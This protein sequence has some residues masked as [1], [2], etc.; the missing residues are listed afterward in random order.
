MKFIYYFL[1]TAVVGLSAFTTGYGQESGGNIFLD[2][3]SAVVTYPAVEWIKGEPVT[4]FDKNKIYIVELWATWCGPCI[5]SMPHMKA[6]ADKFKDKGVILIAQDV[7]E[8]DID[9][10]KKFVSDQG[11]SYNFR[12]AYSGDEGS[13]FDKKWVKAAGIRSIPTTF[14]IQ[15]NKVVWITLP[16]S[17]NEDIIQLLVDGKFTIDAASAFIKVN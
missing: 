15:N 17:V 6:L 7:M 8:K 3:G 1:L 11:D 4:Q 2:E 12:V 9:K 16:T 10:V 5:K 14:I 13:D